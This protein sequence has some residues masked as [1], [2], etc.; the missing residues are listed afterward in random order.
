MNA[1]ASVRPGPA[2]IARAARPFVQSQLGRKQPMVSI[3]PLSI[4]QRRLDTGN[5]AQYPQGSPIGGAMQG[6]GD[7]FSAVAERYQQMKDQQEAFDA[8]LERRRFNGRIAQAEDEVAANVPPDGAGLHEAMYGQVDPRSGQVVKSGLF[9]TLF[10]DALPGMP[11]S[12]RA[13]FA[14]QKEAMRVVG[15]RRMAQRQLQQRKDYEQVETTTVL[16]AITTA[17]GKADPDDT[18]SFETARQDGLDLISKRGLDPQIRQQVVKDWVSTA[19]KAR[20][21]ALIARDPKRPLEMFGVGTPTSGREAPGDAIQAAGSFGK[22]D[23]IGKRTSDPVPDPIVT[24]PAAYPLANLSP[25]DIRRLIDQAH[26]ANTA[27][28][29]EARTNI[30]LASQ[31]APDAI[32]NTGSYAGNM[33]SPGDFAAVYGTEEGGEQYRDF[34]LKLDVGRQTFDMRTMSNQ[35]IHAALSDAEPGPG[36]SLEEQERYSALNEAASRNLKART[37]DPGGYV[38]QIFPDIE[39]AWNDASKNADYQGAIIRSVA[40]Q[41][42]LGIEDVQPLPDSIAKRAVMSFANHN[43][44]V[45]DSYTGN[46]DLFGGI[47]DPTLR[48]KLVIQLI[49]AGVLLSLNINQ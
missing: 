34:S 46:R 30:T 39:L 48:L 11:E 45:S 8:E 2:V 12:Q 17:I 7:Q 21:E 38:R 19:A 24:K 32:A 47:S 25:N 10:D 6:L 16:Q 9:D 44:K 22:G 5:A 3:I 43:A 20:F 29:I 40:A 14:G 13:N 42:Q 15:A 36:S 1:T 18:V 33:P 26:A 23:R 41:Q 4:A 49:Y 35:A 28:L 37:A 27:Q 31:N